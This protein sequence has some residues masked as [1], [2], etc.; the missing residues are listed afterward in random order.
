MVSRASTRCLLCLLLCSA[1]IGVGRAYAQLEQVLA[2]VKSRAQLALEPTGFSTS[3]H[4][5]SLRFPL[6]GPHALNLSGEYFRA[7]TLSRAYERRM[8]VESDW[9]FRSIPITLSYSYALPALNRRMTPVVGMGVSTHF[10][11]ER[12]RRD[13]LPASAAPQAFDAHYGVGVG[14]EATVGMRVLMT[15]RVFVLGQSRLRYVGH[16]AQRSARSMHGPFTL[17]DFSMGIG[18]EL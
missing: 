12:T 2:I 4:T 5:V 16:V 3:A 14:A 9:K 7:S 11:Y 17:L 13:G 8:Q 1:F 6:G 18:F 10:Y 15:P